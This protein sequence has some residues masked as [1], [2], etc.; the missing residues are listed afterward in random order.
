MTPRQIEAYVD[1]ASAALDLKL[2]PDHRAGVL[3]YF[4][5]AAELAAV[6]DAVPLNERD[7][8]ALHFSAVVPPEPG[9]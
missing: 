7:E 2:R 8:P 4:A 6:V 3:R 5:L 9:A 1:A